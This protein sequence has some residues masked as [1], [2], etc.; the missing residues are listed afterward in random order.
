ME[1][2]WERLTFL[3]WTYDPDVV[4]RL[5]PDGLTVETFDDRAWVGLVPFFMRV[6]L[7]RFRDL[8]RLTCFAE[9]N[10]RTYA[11]DADGTPGVWFLSLDATNLPAVVAGRGAYAVPYH[12][13]AMT[14]ADAGD[15][16]VYRCRRRWPAPLPAASEAVVRIGA[17]FAPGEL[18]DLDHWLTARFQLFANPWDRGLRS[19]LADHGIWPLHRAELLHL[20]DTLVTATGLPAPVGEPLV[21]HSFGVDVRIGAPR[22]VPAPGRERAVR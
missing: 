10:V 13:S 8:G 22:R 2:T 11:V 21:H 20:D 18:G 5:L 15:H 12:W 4:Q 7:P 1:Q 9:T 14:V 16:I 3:H 6:G 17:P 19:T